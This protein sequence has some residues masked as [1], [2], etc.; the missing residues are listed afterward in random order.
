MP[1]ID[2]DKLPD[3]HGEPV[4]RMQ[5]KFSGVGTGFTGL[6]V[7]PL[8]MELDDEAFFIVRVK[9][10]ESASHFRDKKDRLVRLQRVHAEDMAPIDRE[11]A[12]QALQSYAQEIKRLKAES[13]GQ[14]ALDAEN[15]AAEREARDG[16]DSPQEIAGAAAKRAKAPKP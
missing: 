6:D 8:V 7:K 16:T 13:S 2:T 11:Q 15:E 3:Y 1:T 5:I 4:D 10:G 12:Q 14:M 9:A